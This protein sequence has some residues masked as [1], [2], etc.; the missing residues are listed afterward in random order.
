MRRRLKS[1]LV[2]PLMSFSI[3]DS[4]SFCLEYV[5]E[6]HTNNRQLC[7]LC[8]MLN[9][10]TILNMS[11]QKPVYGHRSMYMLPW[12][13]L[14]SFLQIHISNILFYFCCIR[15][16]FLRFARWCEWAWSR[17]ACARPCP[18]PA[19]TR[20]V[21][22]IYF[23]VKIMRHFATFIRGQFALST[24]SLYTSIVSQLNFIVNH[25]CKCMKYNGYF[26]DIILS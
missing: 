2:S 10:I 19:A 11:T 21:K 5:T 26:F 13:L 17:W 14:Y 1:P 22:L 3:D 25:I 15:L 12:Q 24:W 23:I 18:D 6:E 16:S 9:L 20:A 8:N 7:V 4:G